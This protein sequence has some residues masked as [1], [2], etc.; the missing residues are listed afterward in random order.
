MTTQGFL[1]PSCW[2]DLPRSGMKLLLNGASSV[3][4]RQLLPLPPPTLPS[5]LFHTPCCPRLSLQLCLSYK[6]DLPRNQLTNFQC[7]F[8][9]Y[10]AQGETPVLKLR[11]KCPNPS[12]TIS[13]A[14]VGNHLPCFGKQSECRLQIKMPNKGCRDSLAPEVQDSCLS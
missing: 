10:G 6:G 3:L 5:F 11:G 7:L 12:S 1:P 9:P 14:P 2:P 13:L 4:C 8:P